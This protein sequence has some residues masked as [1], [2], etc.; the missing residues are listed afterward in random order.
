MLSLQCRPDLSRAWWVLSPQSHFYLEPRTPSRLTQAV[1][2]TQVLR[3]AA[4]GPSL[5]ATGHALLLRPHPC[6]VT[7]APPC[8]NTIKEYGSYAKNIPLWFPLI[9]ALW[10]ARRN[11]HYPWVH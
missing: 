7:W 6:L 4:L 2:R 3:N 10:P 9:P 1:S 11:L 5:A 8:F